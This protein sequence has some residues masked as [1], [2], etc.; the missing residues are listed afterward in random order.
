MA[1]LRAANTGEGRG[2]LS[3]EALSSLGW[4]ADQARQVIAA[5][6]TERARLPDRPGEAPRPL[7]DSPF[8][9]LAALTE[10]PPQRAKRRRPRRK[11][12][13]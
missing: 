8:A 2:R 7:R 3:D 10:P 12:S 6:K 4:T 9:A 5:L 1:D 13:V 11:A